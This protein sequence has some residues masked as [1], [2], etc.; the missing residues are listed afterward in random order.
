LESRHEE[1]IQS[2]LGFQPAFVSH[3]AR[4]ARARI[5]KS[6]ASKPFPDGE[7]FSPEGAAMASRDHFQQELRAQIERAIKR[8]AE[9]LIVS[10]G[11]LLVAVGGRPDPKHQMQYCCDVMRE[12]M[13]AG[14]TGKG[15]GLTIC[16]LL[17]RRLR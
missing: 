6:L 16:Y 10:S 12:E 14:D 3:Q 7:P 9:Q 13:K 5:S 1:T 15:A 2:H 4:G 8:G 11:E 17:S